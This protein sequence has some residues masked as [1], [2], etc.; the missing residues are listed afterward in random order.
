LLAA[1]VMSLPQGNRAA[2]Q[3]ASADFLHHRGVNYQSLA[4]HDLAI[5][6]FDA[7]LLIDPSYAYA[8]VSRGF[9]YAE[10][11]DDDRALRDFEAVLNAPD[12]NRDWHGN[13]AAAYFGRGSIALRRKAYDQAIADFT[14]AVQRKWWRQVAAY[15]SRAQALFE[16][17][18]LAEALADV[19][20]A[21]WV[22][23]Q[24]GP[25]Y[26][27]RSLIYR[28]QNRPLEA[29]SDEMR[30]RL[31]DAFDATLS[32]LVRN[33][34]RTIPV[35]DS[36]SM[37]PGPP[38]VELNYGSHFPSLVGKCA[39]DARHV[40]FI[41][42]GAGTVAVRPAYAAT[43][44]NVAVAQNGNGM[45][46]VLGHEG[47]RIKVTIAK[48]GAEPARSDAT[49]DVAHDAEPPLLEQRLYEPSPAC[50]AATLR[51]R[52]FWGQVEVI[53]D[54]LLSPVQHRWNNPRPAPG[55]AS[56]RLG[57]AG[58]EIEIQTSKA[59]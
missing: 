32:L 33:R 52:A 53:D 38:S 17:G 1:L 54:S 14:E 49:S 8:R 29:I 30:A 4:E 11:G 19:D 9:A 57:G 25:A 2:A 35:D 24:H 27:L 34:D 48:P 41:S 45:T 46:F 16:Q 42:M 6:D 10:K 37:G 31:F 59:E 23:P 36:L 43:G 22:S 56:H 20:R 21:L 50:V 58:C 51:V 55:I 28:A 40:L 18:R 3:A 13:H 26:R 7:A 39:D 12:P 5:A 47:C 44:G 15:T